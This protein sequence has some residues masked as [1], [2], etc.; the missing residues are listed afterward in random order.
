MKWLLLVLTLSTQNAAA[1]MRA[2]RGLKAAGAVV[3]R[4]GVYLLPAGAE[5]RASLADIAGDVEASGGQAYLF[6][7]E[8]TAY[9]FP[10]LFD[11]TEEYGRVAAEAEVLAAGSDAAMGAEQGRQVR[12]LRK[13]FDAIVAIDFFPG[14]AARQTGALLSALEARARADEDSQEPGSRPGRIQRLS[15]DAYRGRTWA[16]RRRPWVDRL[17]SAWLIRRHIDPDARF[18]WLAAP[19]D[20]PPQALG[21]DFDGAAFSHVGERVTFETLLASF[22]LVD[23]PA[24]A[25]LARVVHFLDVGGLPVPEAGGLETL[26]AGMK[27]GIPDDDALLDAAMSSLDYFY[28][29]LKEP[30]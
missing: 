7:V 30:T 27:A 1:R 24:L 21:F 15:R 9:P 29:A 12:K 16:T 5:R 28:S 3:L 25:R 2:W 6:E 14:E 17:A 20:C 8:T 23:D 19:A 10:A 11:R 18:L 4:D 26:L 22:G 13:A